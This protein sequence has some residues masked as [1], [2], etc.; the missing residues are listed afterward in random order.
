MQQVEG[1]LESHGLHVCLLQRR[2]DVHVHVKEPLQHTALLRLLDLQLGQ[3]VHEP[4][5]RTLVTVDPEEVNLGERE[6]ENCEFP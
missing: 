2:G 1:Q 6:E 4:L 5:K 3:Q